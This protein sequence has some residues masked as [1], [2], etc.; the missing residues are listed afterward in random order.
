MWAAQGILT[1]TGGM[2]SHAAVVARGWGKCCI[3]GAGGPAIDYKSRRPSATAQ[4]TLKE[5][6]WI[7]L[8]GST[9]VVYVGQIPTESSPVVS[10]IVGGKKQAQK[11]PIYK[12][13]KQISDWSD[14]YRK[15]NV[16]TN[17]DTPEGRQAAAPSA[18]KASAC[19][20][21]STCSSRRPHLG[22]PRVHPRRQ[23][24]PRKGAGQAAALPAQ[25]LRRHLQGH[26]GLPVTIRLLDPPLHEFV[27]Q[28]RWA[29]KRWPSA[30]AEGRLVAARVQQAARVQPDAG[31][32]RL[33]PL[34]HLS[35]TVR[36]ADPAIIEAA[37]NVEKREDQG[38]PE[39]MVPLIGTKAELDFL[40]RSSARPPTA[41]S[42]KRSPR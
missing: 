22:H 3:C 1:S 32:S 26:E 9:G 42:R 36:H 12:M 6:D 5:G 41:S 8:N 20:A 17:A 11:H 39:I 34:D 16:R 24:G 14:Q 13:Y 37:C 35:R 40:R 31:P 27:P 19:A 10:A 2:T 33:P 29:R 15:I 4:V 38:L 7:S 28:A 30:W 23:Q 18:P 21:P 25:G